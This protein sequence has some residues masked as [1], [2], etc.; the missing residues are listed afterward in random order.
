MNVSS[1]EDISVKNGLTLAAI[2][3]L[4]SRIRYDT[5]HDDIQQRCQNGP[6]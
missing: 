5:K 1:M 3:E 6:T 2:K 4:P